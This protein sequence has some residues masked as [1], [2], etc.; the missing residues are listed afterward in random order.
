MLRWVVAGGWGLRMVLAS[1]VLTSDVSTSD[2]LTRPQPAEGQG[3]GKAKDSC[4]RE[5]KAKDLRQG[6]E[7]KA[8]SLP[9]EVLEMV[10][11][12][13][14]LFAYYSLRAVI[15]G[16][17]GRVRVSPRIG[18]RLLEDAARQLGSHRNVDEKDQWRGAEERI[19][20]PVRWYLR[21]R[22]GLLPR[23]G[24]MEERETAAKMVLAVLEEC[25]RL[26]P[27]AGV[28]GTGWRE[29]CLGAIVMLDSLPQLWG[30]FPPAFCLENER[31]AILLAARYAAL[32]PLAFL[33]ERQSVKARRRLANFY[34]LI[35]SIGASGGTEVYE[36][37]QRLI[38]LSSSTLLALERAAVEHGN[39]ALLKHLDASRGGLERG[40]IEQLCHRAAAVGHLLVFRHLVERL[41]GIEKMPR[42]IV[43][44]VAEH[45]HTDILG[46]VLAAFEGMLPYPHDLYEEMLFL[47]V[48]GGHWAAVGL[49]LAWKS[50]EERIE[51]QRMALT[52][53]LLAGHT[54]VA[55]LLGDD[56]SVTR[57]LELGA[58]HTEILR[59]AIQSGSLGLVKCLLEMIFRGHDV[60]P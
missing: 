34:Q 42:S 48:R 50:A 2:V 9:L 25:Q 49:L 12:H 38:P 18:E 45:G 6:E 43:L 20:R 8:F 14:D 31:R 56:G 44:C 37:F 4:Q 7:E 55:V 1:D 24:A 27:L 13:A 30:H 10:I 57:H 54:D 21:E 26:A 52:V 41:G 11:G 29:N 23:R 39:L 17:E 28:H 60:E 19:L 32:Q 5:G 36:L 16:M 47:A 59:G 40:R 51:W 35:D 22:I 3:E 33:V 58:S 15:R 53:A 46:A